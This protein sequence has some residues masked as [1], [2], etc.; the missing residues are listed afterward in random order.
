MTSIQWDKLTCHAAPDYIKVMNASKVKT[1]I[2]SS[3]ACWTP[4]P[5]RAYYNL[6]VQNPIFDDI[7][8]LVVELCNPRLAC[9]EL[10]VDLKPRDNVSESEVEALMSHTFNAVARGFR[11]EDTAF[12]QYGYRGGL[13]RRGVSP[14]PF[15][16]RVPKYTEQLIYGWRGDFLQSKMYFKSTDE[17]RTLSIRDQSVRMELTMRSQALLE[18]R[19]ERVNDLVGYPFRSMFAEHFRMISGVRVR[20]AKRL[21]DVDRKKLD[22]KIQLR[23]A[24]HGVSG[25]ADNPE[26]RPWTSEKAVRMKKVRSAQQIPF[27]SFVLMRDRFSNDKIGAALKQLERRMK[28]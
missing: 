14:M 13:E 9:F 20:A 21:S 5:S 19:I 8:L 22:K 2:F 10:R 4:E 18:Y 6:T 28:H 7:Q 16:R 26:Q 23:F 12:A 17:G 15:H 27:D 24:K 1:T 3:S 11:P 25:F